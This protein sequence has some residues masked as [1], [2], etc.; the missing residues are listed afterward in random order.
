MQKN[1][2]TMDHLANIQGQESL[3]SIGVCSKIRRSI[4]IHWVFPLCLKDR[5]NTSQIV[6][7]KIVDSLFL[8]FLWL[9]EL[10]N[11]RGGGI[12]HLVKC[13]K[14]ETGPDCDQN[15]YLQ[16]NC[17]LESTVL[18]YLIS[19]KLNTPNYIIFICFAVYYSVDCT[20]LH[21]VRC[22]YLLFFVWLVFFSPAQFCR[23]FTKPW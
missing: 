12:Q 7:K 1:I 9:G 20:L 23:K 18:Y 19:W 4:Q 2:L 8:L 3:S 11:G 5:I 17:L 14:N 15:S 13:I 6:I 21:T 22:F 16:L 10:A